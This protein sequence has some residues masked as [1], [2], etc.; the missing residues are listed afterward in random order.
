MCECGFIDGNRCTLWCEISIVWEVVGGEYRAIQELSVLI[1][2]FPCSVQ[3]SRSVGSDSLWPHESQH[4]RPPCPSPTPRVHLDS[5][6]SSQWCHPA[7]SYSVFRFSS[8]PKS[9]PALES[10]PMSQLISWGG[11]CTGVSVLAS[12]LPKNIQGLSPSERTGWISLQFKGLWRVF[13]NTTKLLYS[14][15]N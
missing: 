4:A 8:C 2:Q 1:A 13:S 3:F 9:F 7:I 5:R 10:F 6:L 11:Q 12:F 15:K 14:K